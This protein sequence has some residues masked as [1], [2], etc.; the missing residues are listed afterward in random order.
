MENDS[1]ICKLIQNDL[2]DDFISHIK[3]YNLP[4][5]TLIGQSNF[6]TNH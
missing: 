3:S 4:L 6:E 2:I 1:Y 5:S